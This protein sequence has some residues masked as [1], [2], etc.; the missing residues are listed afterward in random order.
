MRKCGLAYE[1]VYYSVPACTQAVGLVVIGAGAVNASICLDAF[2]NAGFR[3]RSVLI[4]QMPLSS[5]P[6]TGHEPGGSDV[7][8]EH[9]IVVL[10]IG[11]S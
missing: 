9:F 7:N 6:T 1:A 11:F 2:E 5:L 3:F 8:P 10:I 4:P